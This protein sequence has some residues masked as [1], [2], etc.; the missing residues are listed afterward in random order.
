MKKH[1]LKTDPYAWDTVNYEIKTYELR[2][3]D[4]DFQPGDVLILDRTEYSGAE[5][6]AGAPLRY[7][8]GRG[9]ECEVLHV[10]KGPIYG[11]SEGWC[12]LSIR[13]IRTHS[14]SSWEL[15]DGPIA[16]ASHNNQ[17]IAAYRS[18]CWERYFKEIQEPL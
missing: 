13:K 2:F 8:D 15:S 1:Y 5:I 7:Y 12:I 3:N 4:R 16:Y 9:I 11:L 17:T 18:E 10:L 6:K 14:L